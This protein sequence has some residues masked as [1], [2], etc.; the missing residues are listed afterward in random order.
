MMFENSRQYLQQVLPCSPAFHSLAL[1]S[2]AQGLFSRSWLK[3]IDNLVNS[4]LSPVCALE[5]T[6]DLWHCNTHLK[7]KSMIFM[8]HKNHIGLEQLLRNLPLLIVFKCYVCADST[9]TCRA[10]P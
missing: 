7:I 8:P 4:N 6:G 3:G 1:A 9:G 5:I 2:P 10:F